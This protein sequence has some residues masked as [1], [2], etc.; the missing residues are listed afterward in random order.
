MKKSIDRHLGN[1]QMLMLV[2]AIILCLTALWAVGCGGGGSY[3]G[4]TTPTTPTPS[5]SSGAVGATITITST[6]L[7]NSAP[8][9]GVGERVRFVNNDTKSHQILT[10]PHRIHTDCPA[11][12]SIGML[13]PG[14]SGTSDPLTSSRGCGFHDHLDPDNNNLRGQV[15]VGISL[16]EP[17]PPPPGYLHK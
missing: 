16:G 7:S 5:G 17:P 6:G 10:T 1:E 13:S 14:A 3:N 4:G 9:I 2:L 11:L 12:N 15:L 8:N